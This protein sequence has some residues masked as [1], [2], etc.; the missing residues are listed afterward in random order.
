MALRRLFDLDTKP[1]FRTASDALSAVTSSRTWPQ[2]PPYF[3]FP[4]Q[5]SFR[6]MQFVQYLA[7]KLHLSC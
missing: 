4:S 5:H 3:P 6:L 7:V 2:R 1:E